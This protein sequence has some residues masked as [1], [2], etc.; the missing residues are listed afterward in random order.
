MAMMVARKQVMY[1][2]SMVMVVLAT[3]SAL[4]EESQGMMQQVETTA[5]HIGEKIEKKAKAVVKKVEE[6]HV[7]EKVEQ[8]LKK[9]ATKTAE[10][11][12]KAGTKI[13]EKLG[14]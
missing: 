1:A 11:F 12:E 6:K 3:G 14:N 13:K 4:A 5:K 8:K 10:G 7:V 2:L 9:A